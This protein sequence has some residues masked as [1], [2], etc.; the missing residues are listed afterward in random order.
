MA[1]GHVQV[2]LT[3]CFP[4]SRRFDWQEVK[5]PSHTTRPSCHSPTPYI[6]LKSAF[7]Q[8]T[9]K[10][11]PISKITTSFAIKLLRV[12]CQGRL[13]DPL[14]WQKYFLSGSAKV[15]YF[16]GQK[17]FSQAAH[18]LL[19]FLLVKSDDMMDDYLLSCRIGSWILS[20]EDVSVVGTWS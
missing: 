15:E 18:V 19:G 11:G 17:G 7:P 9:C 10:C 3:T 5:V 8:Q 16:V 1:C 20:H 12:F 4:H 6:H 2:T 13:F 14:D